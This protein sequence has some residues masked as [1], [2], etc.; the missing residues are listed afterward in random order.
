MIK[1]G[2]IK[3]RRKMNRQYDIVSVR[4]INDQYGGGLNSKIY[5]YLAPT[6]WNVQ[7]GDLV[8]HKDMSLH[9]KAIVQNKSGVISTNKPLTILDH[10]IPRQS[11]K[12]TVEVPF[13]HK[14]KIVKE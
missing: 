5:N 11:T 9:S 6:E 7:S 14:I 2:D 1:L 3:L 8:S 13:G 10:H 12:V 4:F